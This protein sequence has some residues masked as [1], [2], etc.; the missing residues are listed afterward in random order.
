MCLLCQISFIIYINDEK[1][2]PGYT[3]YFNIGYL[4]VNGN[5][6]TANHMTFISIGF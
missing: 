4:D 2:N 5:L 6:I 3:I 1:F